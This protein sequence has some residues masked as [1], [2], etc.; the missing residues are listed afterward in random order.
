[1]T[2]STIRK[3]SDIPESYT[4]IQ[5]SQD[6]TATLESIGRLDLVHEAGCLFVEVLD[7]DYGQV[8]YANGTSPFLTNNVYRIQ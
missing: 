6:I 8:F 4:L 1:M 3:V 5:D 7:G 2:A